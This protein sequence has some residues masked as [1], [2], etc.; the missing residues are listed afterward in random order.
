MVGPTK[1]NSGVLMGHA[2]FEKLK[3]LMS[4]ALVSPIVGLVEKTLEHVAAA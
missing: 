4:L 3:I 1:E 2:C